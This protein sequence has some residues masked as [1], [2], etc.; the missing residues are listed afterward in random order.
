[1]GVGDFA[2]GL[3]PVAR[4]GTRQAGGALRTVLELSIDG[5]AGLPGA[6][7]AAKSQLQKHGSADDAIDAVVAQHVALSSAQGFMSNVGGVIASVVSIPGNLA[8]L[9]A[10]QIR[11]VA[12][13]AHLRG[14]DIDDNRVRTAMVMCLL[15]GDQIVRLIRKGVLP[16]TPMAVA[17]APV[18]DPDLDRRVAERVVMEMAA[19]VG[20]TNGALLLTKRIP[21]IGGGVG[22]V[23]DGVATRQIGVFASGELRRRR[24]I[25]H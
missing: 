24:S 5:F 7:A 12:A 4:N 11:M 1:M 3:V 13:I 16:T 20:G 2:R 17:T 14:Y 21:L 8:G 22:A 18:F 10:V 19:R 23:V 25:S 6:K 9:A 15:G